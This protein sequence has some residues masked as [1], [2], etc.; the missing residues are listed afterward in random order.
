MR[1]LSGRSYIFLAATLLL[2]AAA[3]KVYSDFA[4]TEMGQAQIYAAKEA[5]CDWASLE[6][7]NMRFGCH[8]NLI[9]GPSSS[10]RIIKAGE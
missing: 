3:L 1:Q 6:A 5:F 2:L 9:G 10:T 8:S 7:V 4:K